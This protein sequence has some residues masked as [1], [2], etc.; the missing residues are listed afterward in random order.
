MIAPHSGSA[1]DGVTYTELLARAQVGAARLRELGVEHLVYVA[2][3]GPE[4]PVALFAAARS[5]F[6]WSR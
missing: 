2:T 4:F 3:N 5:R 6:P 1:D